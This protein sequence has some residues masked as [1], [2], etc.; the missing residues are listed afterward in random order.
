M[1]P[2]SGSEVKENK[3]PPIPS[4]SMVLP[5]LKDPILKVLQAEPHRA[6]KAEELVQILKL[7]ASKD[8]QKQLQTLEQVRSELQK[9]IEAGR[10]TE[11]A[12][13]LFKA[14]LF[15]DKEEFIEHA[16]IGEM[17]NTTYRFQSPIFRLN[18][19]VLSVYFIRY[20]KQGDWIA[21]IRDTTIGKD[22]CLVRRLRD[23]TYTIGSRPAVTG[24]DRHLQIEGKYIS[25]KH[26]T[27]TVSGDKI[28]IEDQKTPN[29]TRIDFL[30][31]EGVTHYEQVAEDFLQGTDTIGQMESVQRGRFVLERLL[32]DHQNFETSF[33]NAVVDLL[34]LQG[35]PKK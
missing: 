7:S 11:V 4:L 29:G 31:Q 12:S 28:N 34:L 1:E 13:G 18:I 25:K 32:H 9:L 5:N 16:L 8:P 15:F 35:P 10:I 3:V 24:E 6:F 27:L 19:G 26:L 2:S 17:G 23:G 14:R 22:Y 21:T 20:R 30:T 33:F